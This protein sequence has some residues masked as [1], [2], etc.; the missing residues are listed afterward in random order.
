MLVVP[1][2]WSDDP[3]STSV[4]RAWAGFAV[5]LMEV[6][7]FHGGVA[8]LALGAALLVLKRWSAAGAL[9]VL[10]A[11]LAGPG[12]A[13]FVG[14][15]RER[16]SPDAPGLTVLASNLLFTRAD[17]D[18]LREQAR[19]E[20]PDVIL[21]QEVMP[22][23]GDEIRE[24]FASTHPHTVGPTPGRW[25][26]MILSRLPIE[27]VDPIPGIEPWSIGQAAG[28][29]RVADG[30]SGHD[31]L[32]VSTHLPA[33]T[34]VG[35]FVA[36]V[37]MAGTVADWVERVRTGPDAPDAVI[38]AGD[39][40]A[41][42]WTTRLTPL[43]DAGLIEAHA[44]VGAGR[45]STWPVKTPLRFAP[46]IRLDQAAAVGSGRWA[47]SRVLGPIGSDHRPIVARYV[48]E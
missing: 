8:L 32:V 26:T 4:V 43:R 17:M 10:G 28:L 3:A 47:E 23:R 27:A 15:E 13:E 22:D 1:A 36:G 11:A 30:E 12:L 25:G 34:R 29:V 5:L 39:F 46:G 6:F 2:V 37:C 9:L 18:T 14:T 42:L 31:V 45:G 35:N 7:A 33:P 41:P 40:N 38:L 20:S 24:R 48:F 21:L 19:R 44:A 16:A